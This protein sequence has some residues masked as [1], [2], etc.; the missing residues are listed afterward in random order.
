MHHGGRSFG[1]VFLPLA[2]AAASKAGR[3]GCHECERSR[4]AEDRARGGDGKKK[5][6]SEVPAAFGATLLLQAN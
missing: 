4:A 1:Q 2:P 3:P 5:D 6:T